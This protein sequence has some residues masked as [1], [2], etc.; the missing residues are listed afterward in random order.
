VRAE[1][2]EDTFEK[3]GREWYAQQPEVWVPEHA[4]RI[5]SRLERDVFPFLG[6][7]P[8]T[9]IETPELLG[10]PSAHRSARSP[11]DPPRRSSGF[12]SR[13]RLDASSMR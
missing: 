12:T 3:I 7:R 6:G 10:G 9:A 8:M 5:L 11:R 2:S 13:L 1:Q 4:A